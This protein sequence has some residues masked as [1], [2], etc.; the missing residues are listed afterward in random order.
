[1]N[2]RIQC[3]GYGQTL[4]RPLS[5]RKISILKLTFLIVNCI[6]FFAT[7]VAQ[8]GISSTSITPHSSS[9]L[10][11]RSTTLGFLPPRMTTTERGAIASPAN[12]LVI[13]NTTTNLLNF[14]NGSSWQITGGGNACIAASL[15]LIFLP[16]FIQVIF[17]KR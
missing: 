2:T 4:L 13:Y 5:I 14:Y 10:E 1:M 8:V 7:S 12:G 15:V 6:L 17:L 16:L 9:I 3:I 11:L